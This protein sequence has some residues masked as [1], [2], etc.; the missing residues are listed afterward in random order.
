MSDVSL[1]DA[2]LS[3]ASGGDDSMW[4]RLAEE[5]EEFGE[6]GVS[7]EYSD[8]FERLAPDA[9]TDHAHI[10]D[11]ESHAAHEI[12]ESRSLKLQDA[13]VTMLFK[14][15]QGHSRAI[16]G[17]ARQDVP[18]RTKHQGQQVGARHLEARRSSSRKSEL[19]IRF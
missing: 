1:S 16:S 2:E 15:S 8:N 6:A 9:P 11:L 19:I 3:I 10:I 17:F 12:A 5:F 4:D 14:I 7:V 18:N 13:V